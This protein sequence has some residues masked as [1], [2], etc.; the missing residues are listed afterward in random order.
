MQTY[1]IHSYHS[2]AV[3]FTG[4]FPSFKAC[5]EQAVN[6]N[7]DLAFADLSYQ[8]LSGAMLDGARIHK[9]DFG[10][11]N[12]SGANISEADLAGS[13]FAGADLY[14]TC[15]AYSNL[16]KAVFINAGFGATDMAQASI[17]NCAFSSSSC[18]S[19]DF[20]GVKA[21][22]GCTYLSDAG[23][24]YAMSSPPVVIS[25]ASRRP[26]IFLDDCVI[27]GQNIWPHGR[28]VGILQR[29]PSKP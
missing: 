18:F 14:N 11:A 24:S 6:D 9:A 7:A 15:M 20:T 17:Q 21:M 1:T 13:R 2:K 16:D 27:S 29:H 19:I 8:D 4:R 28:W 12:L 25:G 3:L 23:I 5:L 26:I 22:T 10:G